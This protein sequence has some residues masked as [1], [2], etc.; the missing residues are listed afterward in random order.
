MPGIAGVVMDNI[1]L[2]EVAIDCFFNA[3][4]PNILK[5]A[6]SLFNQLQFGRFPFGL[7]WP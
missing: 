7:A 6:R 2:G 5:E 4:I 1:G 3:P